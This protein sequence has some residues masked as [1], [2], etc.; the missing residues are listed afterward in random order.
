MD[1]SDFKKLEIEQKE[2]NLRRG[3]V[4]LKKEEWF[5]RTAQAHNVDPTKS[6]KCRHGIMYTNDKE[7][8]Q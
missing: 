7:E 4:L 2:C 1:L 6:L 3:A 5:H 8:N